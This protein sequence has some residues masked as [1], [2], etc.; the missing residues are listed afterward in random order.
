MPA[1]DRGRTDLGPIGG[2]AVVAL[3]LSIWSLMTGNISVLIIAVCFLVG[4]LFVILLVSVNASP[5]RA[6]K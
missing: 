1:T 6:R 5:R 2:L 3:V 4:L